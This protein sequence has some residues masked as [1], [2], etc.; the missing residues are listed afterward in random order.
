MNDTI[1]LVTIRDIGITFKTMRNQVPNF[2]RKGKPVSVS[3]P[4]STAR[5][6]TLSKPHHENSFSISHSSLEEWNF[7][8]EAPTRPAIVDV[9]IYV[10]RIKIMALFIYFSRW[11]N[12]YK[13][14]SVFFI[15]F[16]SWP[17][18]TT[19][20]YIYSVFFREHPRI[21]KLSMQSG[22]SSELNSKLPSNLQME[23]FGY[24]HQIVISVIDSSP[25]F[26]LGALFI[27][28]FVS[29]SSPFVST[30]QHPLGS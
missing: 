16:V 19:M 18:K 8:Q 25:G 3:M 12:L 5:Q 14:L 20:P 7:V 10:R 11:E 9:K 6:Y 13:A 2:T 27:L 4:S 29:P 22:I 1:S 23:L 21:M 24:S 26:F 15:T 30:Q 28:R 17:V